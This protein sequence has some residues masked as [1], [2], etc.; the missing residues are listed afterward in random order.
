MIRKSDDRV[1]HMG[2]HKR[3]LPRTY[4]LIDKSELP[5]GFEGRTE[6]LFRDWNGA[7]FT[8]QEADERERLHS[9]KKR[10]LAA[11]LEALKKLSEQHEKNRFYH[12]ASYSCLVLIVL[13]VAVLSF[14]GGA[15]FLY[16]DMSVRYI[17]H[18][19]RVLPNDTYK[20]KLEIPVCSPFYCCNII[21]SFI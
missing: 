10:K 15:Y 8:K 3:K 20:Y 6:P 17:L 16:K 13:F 9:E 7:I 2:F 19:V 1:H 14:T 4:T 12:S 11:K 5:P 18:H 21:L